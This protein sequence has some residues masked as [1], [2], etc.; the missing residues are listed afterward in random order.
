M[1]D[2]ELYSKL[3]A[4]PEELK[5][6]ADDFVEFLKT[7]MNEKK[8]TQKKEAGLAKGLIEMTDDFDE[9][10]EGFESYRE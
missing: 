1:N 5:Q 9:P 2:I 3:I 7:K 10:L 4:L 6:E 8:I